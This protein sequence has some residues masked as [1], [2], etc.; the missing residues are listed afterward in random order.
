VNVVPEENDDVPEDAVIS[1][2]PAGNAQAEPNATITI[3]VSSGSG[4]IPIPEVAG[5]TEATARANLNS[6]G[7][8]SISVQNE[9]NDDVPAGT[10]IR[11]DPAPGTEVPANQAITLV[12]SAG[13]EQV[14]VPPVE[15]LNE[16]NA[17]SQL[18]AAGLSVSVSEQ[19]VSNPGQDGRVLSQ[20][21]AANQR[22]NRG[23]TV[24]IVVGRLQSTPGD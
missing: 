15:G 24:N 6:A 2:D 5:Q 22:V 19:D 14:T 12:L 23:D 3:R 16:Q 8:T 4:L 21:P 20:S 13:R 7:F 17:R 9:Q 11:V 18:E 1:Q 10:V